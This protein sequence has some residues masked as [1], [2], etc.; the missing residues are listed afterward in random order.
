MDM[1][2]LNFRASCQGFIDTDLSSTASNPSPGY[3]SYSSSRVIYGS[4][5][6]GA[7]GPFE[8]PASTHI[9]KVTY[10]HMAGYCGNGTMF[11]LASGATI[12]IKGVGSATRTNVWDVPADRQFVGL[13]G[14][15]WGGS[16]VDAGPTGIVNYANHL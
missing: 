7:V 10:Y 14:F 9:S 16:S 3:V 4:Q 13:N 15:T 1:L 2:Q 12:T 5:G 8:I 6:G 11:T